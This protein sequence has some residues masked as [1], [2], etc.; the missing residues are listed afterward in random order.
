[1]YER[2]YNEKISRELRE[3]LFDRSDPAS[4]RLLMMEVQARLPQYEHK[5]VKQLQ[6]GQSEPFKI[7]AV[8]PTVSQEVLDSIPLEELEAIVAK[9]RHL[10][11]QSR[12]D[13]GLHAIE[14]G[15]A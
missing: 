11:E 4:A 3:R 5:R 7:Q 15:R 6:V 2:M 9:L 12:P 10:E 1:M 13:A 8:I 14:G